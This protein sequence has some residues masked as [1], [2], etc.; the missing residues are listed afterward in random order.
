MSKY[1]LLEF[2]KRSVSD[3]KHKVTYF[4]IVYSFLGK[5]GDLP[6]G[7][8]S[9]EGRCSANFEDCNGCCLNIRKKYF[10][11]IIENIFSDIFVRTWFKN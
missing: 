1:D 11:L 8:S 10:N 2:L 9:R 6:S 4:F 7:K 5:G 3:S